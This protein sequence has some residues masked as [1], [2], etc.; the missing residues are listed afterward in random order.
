MT[1]DRHNPI[2]RPPEDFVDDDDF[3]DPSHMN[4]S[5]AEKFSRWL[6]Q[7]V[8]DALRAADLRRDYSAEH[9]KKLKDPQAGGND[10]DR[11]AKDIG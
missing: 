10:D 1:A 3:F 9:L 4:G 5:G 8:A 2:V 6:A 11:H 7:D